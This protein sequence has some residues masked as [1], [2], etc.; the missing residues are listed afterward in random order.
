MHKWTDAF[1]FFLKMHLDLWNLYTQ[2]VNQLPDKLPV[3]Q[4]LQSLFSNT[5]QLNL[6]LNL[7]VIHMPLKGTRMETASPK[8]PLRNRFKKQW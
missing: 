6:S 4:I 1:F 7:Y 5:V 3:P 2:A 8:P